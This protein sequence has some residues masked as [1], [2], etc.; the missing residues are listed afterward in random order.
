MYQ[1]QEGKKNE[2][3]KLSKR[4]C[5]KQNIS[6][7]WNQ[8]C[9]LRTLSPDQIKDKLINRKFRVLSL[10]FSMPRKHTGQ[11]VSFGHYV[12]EQSNILFDEGENGSTVHR[13]PGAFVPKLAGSGNTDRDSFVI[14]EKLFT[15]KFKALSARRCSP[16][17]AVRYWNISRL[18][19]SRSAL[20]QCSR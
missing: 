4:K 9:C 10:M 2:L 11:I 15:I 20:Y 7:S 13:H 16:L 18:S 3:A 19:D 6:F 12:Q 14:S 5:E 1:K 8:T 17:G